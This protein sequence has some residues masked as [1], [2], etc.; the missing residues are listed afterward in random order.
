MY[1]SISTVNYRVLFFLHFSAI[2]AYT[3]KSD[4]LSTIY[5]KK[6]TETTFSQY[7]LLYSCHLYLFITSTKTTSSSIIL[8]QHPPGSHPFRENKR[9]ISA[10]PQTITNYNIVLCQSSPTLNLSINSISLFNFPT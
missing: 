8:L 1:L 4:S 5:C 3:V 2:L 7:I 6:C 10:P 9:T